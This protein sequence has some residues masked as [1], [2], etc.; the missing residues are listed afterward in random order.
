MGLLSN[1]FMGATTR[2]QKTGTDYKV[3]TPNKNLEDV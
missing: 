1:A 3:S 2:F